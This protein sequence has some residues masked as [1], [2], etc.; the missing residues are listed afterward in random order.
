MRRQFLALFLLTVPAAQGG[1]QPQWGEA[2]TRNQVSKERNL[3]A[4]FDPRS[5]K[6]V[7]WR[8]R[9]GTETH[10]TPIIAGGRV[11]IG[12]NNREPR[13]PKHQGDRG[14][15]M[16]FRESSGEW[17]W[18]LVVPKRAEDPYFD[19]P[20]CGI[21]SSVT[22]EGNRVY[23]TTNRGE[24]L[25]LD[26][27]GL[28]DGNEGPFRDEGWHMTPDPGLAGNPSP[29]AGAEIQPRRRANPAAK[30]AHL[31]QPGPTDADIV[32]VFDMIEDAGIWPHDGAHSS[33]LI[34]G[35]HLYLNTATGV[36]NTH[37][38]IRTPD[39]P[40]LIVLD[41][42]TG[43]YLA[44]E[45]EGIAPSIFH[46]TWSAPAMARIGGRDRILFCG[47]N[48]IVYAFEPLD[49]EP[50]PGEVATLKKL[51]QF[52]IDPTA[53]KT[54]VHRFNQNRSEGPSTIFAM[55]VIHQGRLYVAG[56]GDTWWGKNESWLFCIDPSGSGDVTRQNLIWRAPLGYHVMSTPAVAEGLVFIADTTRT[57]HCFDA[58]TGAPLWKH[59]AK[60]DFWG[61]PLVADG[62]VYIGSRR[63][64][65]WIFK[66][67]RDKEILSQI[68]LGAPMSATPTAARGTL[69]VAT[70]FELF[71][72]A[73]DPKK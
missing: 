58:E 5:G 57:V 24:V 20:H 27:G 21:P 42:R 38:R 48:G 70:M 45:R 65:F 56:G 64:D 67:S 23:T 19:W 4:E 72:V 17:L 66:A 31:L 51:W 26:A 10:S 28:S 30:S 47:G 3:P 2:W 41:K 62:K 40:S 50:V 53:P 6:N 13:D 68:D 37:K 59:E 63:G 71:A 34:R 15:I 16:C 60:G 61:S 7:R 43:R 25:C 69:Y 8:A 73:K 39:A 18:Q 32:W 49:R 12:T 36:D 35:N 22:V 14:V 44:R 1:D 11:Y 46:N 55:P 33:I 29:V 9:L 54:E 52:D